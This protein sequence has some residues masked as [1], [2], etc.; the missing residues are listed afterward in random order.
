MSESP[1]SDPDKIK[2][3]HN[4]DGIEEYDNPLPG[5]W[6]WLFVA[7]IV[8]T[9]MYWLFYHSGAEGRT[10]EGQYGFALAENT[11][12]QFA[13]IGDLKPD[14]ETITRFMAGMTDYVAKP[15]NPKALKEILEKHLGK[16][17]AA[18][19][20]LDLENDKNGATSQ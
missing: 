17:D 9:P 13:E 6:K 7:S 15:V 12:L 19:L 18:I 1:Q 3:D 5:W 11:R 14:A 16:F 10:L 20:D 8:F 2:M 4:Y